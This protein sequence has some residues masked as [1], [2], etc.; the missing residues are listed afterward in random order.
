MKRNAGK[1][2]ILKTAGMAEL[3]DALDLGSSEATRTG[4]I[5]ATRTIKNSHCDNHIILCIM[6]A[7]LSLFLLV[8]VESLLLA[9]DHS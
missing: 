1:S 4:S 7:K 8:Q 6:M 3:A 9:L 5:P 2:R